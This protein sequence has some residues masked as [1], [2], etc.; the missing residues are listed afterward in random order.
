M[1]SLKRNY[2]FVVIPILFFI[3]VL[4]LMDI[5]CACNGYKSQ[6]VQLERMLLSLRDEDNRGS[7]CIAYLYQK[8][9]HLPLYA[10][11]RT[12]Y[13]HPQQRQLDVRMLVYNR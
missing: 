3:C 12:L 9:A 2:G 13:L 6:N 10:T 5:R 8:Q 1:N 7:V 11:D 4:G